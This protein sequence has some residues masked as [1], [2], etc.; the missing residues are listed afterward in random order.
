MTSELE[1]RN[2]T[3]IAESLGS[4][5]EDMSMMRAEIIE[6]KKTLSQTIGMIQGIQQ[7]Q[8]HGLV[9][10]VGTGPTSV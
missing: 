10:Q 3:A 6:L 5:S 2:A 4:M 7:R 8:I 1:T 9:A